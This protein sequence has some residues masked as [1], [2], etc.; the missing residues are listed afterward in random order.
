MRQRHRFGQSQIGVTRVILGL[1]IRMQN[2]RTGRARAFFTT[3][4]GPLRIV[5]RDQLSPSYSEMG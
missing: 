1:D 2:K 3:C 4:G 5:L